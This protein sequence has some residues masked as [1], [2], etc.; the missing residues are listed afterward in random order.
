MPQP[1]SDARVPPFARV[2]YEPF[3]R[4]SV[5]AI[6][7]RE[8]RLFGEPVDDDPPGTR[9]R[10]A[11]EDKPEREP[12]LWQRVG[13]YWWLGLDPGSPEIRLDG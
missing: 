3:S 10:P 9:P 1:P 4:T 12:G 13:E 5:V 6:A 2:P 7:L 8:W 11:P